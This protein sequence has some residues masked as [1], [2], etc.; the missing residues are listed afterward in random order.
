[1]CGMYRLY[2]CIDVID[3][4][5]DFQKQS[6]MGSLWS[7]LTKEKKLRYVS[8]FL[9]PSISHRYIS[10]YV[11]MDCDVRIQFFTDIL[12]RNDRETS[13]IFANE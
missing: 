11:Y 3:S 4:F 5:E 13:E 7:A 1:M 8:L 6:K 2:R 9:S 12:M 10:L